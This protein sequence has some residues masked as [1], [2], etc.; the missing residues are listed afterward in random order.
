MDSTTRGKGRPKDGRGLQVSR[1]L[2]GGRT[3]AK[4]QPGDKLVIDKVEE[5]ARK[6]GIT[7]AEVALAWSIASPWVTAPIIG[8]KTT[9]RLDELLRALD[10]KLTDEELES[11]NEQYSPVKV[12]AHV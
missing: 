12:R 4:R 7:M 2:L 5:I 11:I 6:R 1:R 10:L 9:E 8:I 3:V